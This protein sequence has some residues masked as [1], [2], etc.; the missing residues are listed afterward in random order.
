[1]SKFLFHFPLSYDILIKTRSQQDVA[2]FGRAKLAWRNLC[3]SC[4]HNWLYDNQ[5]SYGIV[6][7]EYSTV[8]LCTTDIALSNIQKEYEKG[9]TG[10]LSSA[11]IKQ[12]RDNCALFYFL[13]IQTIDK[14][15]NYPLV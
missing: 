14:R 9:L 5:L 13:S 12:A 10:M 6:S 8:V 4:V 2:W 3:T 7:D 15:K 1:M 11:I